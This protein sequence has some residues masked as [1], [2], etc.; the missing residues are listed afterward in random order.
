MNHAYTNVSRFSAQ[1]QPTITNREIDVL[2]LVSLGMSSVQIG[3][4]L[5]ITEETV[6]SHRKNMR[7]K[8]NVSNGA[9]LVRVAFEFGFLK[10]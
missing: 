10:I 3:K 9:A 5:Y 2:K 6:K 1:T 8:F 7:Q 4:Q